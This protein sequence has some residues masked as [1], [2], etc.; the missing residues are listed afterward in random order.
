MTR[1]GENEAP[2]FV[3]LSLRFASLRP[4]PSP[5]GR[6]VGVRGS[7]AANARRRRRADRANLP[8]TSADASAARSAVVASGTIL[9][10]A[11][12]LTLSSGMMG[13][14]LDRDDG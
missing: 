10:A 1:A 12:T 13:D 6:G 2:H 11:R 5:G 14:N 9:S 8:T 4:R 3:F 7:T